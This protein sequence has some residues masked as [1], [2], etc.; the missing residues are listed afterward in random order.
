M[1]RILHLIVMT[2]MPCL[3]TAQAPAQSAGVQWEALNQEA[4]ELYR[5]GQY[6]RAVM[7]AKEALKLAEQK[8]GPDHPH[9]ARSLTDLA[10]L[11]EL[12]RNYAQAEPLYKRALAIREKALEPDHP[13][14]AMSLNSL[15]GLY[16]AQ[17]NYAQA[18][19]L[20]KRALAIREKALRGRT[21]PMWPRA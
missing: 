8:V 3:A 9:V 13:Y 1:R 12:Q 17:R 6:G 20:Y 10:E 4:R 21:I 14:V 5:T 7:V 15:A 16:K 18:E 19:P 11:Y 2:I